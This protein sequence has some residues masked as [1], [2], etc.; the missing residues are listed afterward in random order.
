V[1]LLRAFGV[2]WLR[3]G[4]VVESYAFAACGKYIRISLYDLDARP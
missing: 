4:K 3:L 2:D 1:S